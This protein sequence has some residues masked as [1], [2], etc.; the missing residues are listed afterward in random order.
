MDIY[1]RQTNSRP[2]SHAMLTD[3]P[4]SNRKLLPGM[5]FGSK[6]PASQ[7]IPLYSEPMYNIS[8]SLKQP[9]AIAVKETILM[10]DETNTQMGFGAMESDNPIDESDIDLE[11]AKKVNPSILEAFST[12][13]FKTLK[14]KFIP[15]LK[16]KNEET[17]VSDKKPKQKKTNKLKFY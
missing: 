12:P 15:Q 1:V 10:P 14:T 5:A 13:V 7:M 4:S 11:G 6:Q 16:R 2:M 17:D 8:K 9:S 3:Y